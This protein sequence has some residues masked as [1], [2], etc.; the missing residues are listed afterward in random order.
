MDKKVRRKAEFECTECGEI[1][2]ATIVHHRGKALAKHNCSNC[3][4]ETI[5]E[6][7]GWVEIEIQ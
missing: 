5:W 1:K 7:T 3:M 6:E 4:E 2:E